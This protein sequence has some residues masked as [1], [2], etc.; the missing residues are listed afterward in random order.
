M[1]VAYVVRKGRSGLM[2]EWTAIEISTLKKL[3]DEG[4]S[5]MRIA[6]RLGRSTIA[7]VAIAKR[8]GIRLKS[9]SDV[10]KANGLSPKWS[11]NS[12]GIS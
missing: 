10:R 2:T 12:L 6:A 7:V 3:A 4:A 5:R 1:L 8:H 11:S 9:V